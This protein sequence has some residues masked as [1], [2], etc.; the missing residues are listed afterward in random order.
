MLV[1]PLWWH[2]EVCWSG[3]RVAW[4]LQ[5]QVLL[6]GLVDSALVGV[7]RCG[8]SQVRTGA[9]MASVVAIVAVSALTLSELAIRHLPVRCTSIHL[10]LHCHA[11]RCLP[12]V[13]HRHL[14]NPSTGLLI[15]ANLQLIHQEAKTRDQSDEI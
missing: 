7:D 1:V 12:L 10:W 5:K 14:A 15:V 9:I 2:V 13:C 3:V 4:C 11:V 8:M 6:L